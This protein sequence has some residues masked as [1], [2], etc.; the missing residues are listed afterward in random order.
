MNSV[1]SLQ[2]Y[3]VGAT[4]DKVR[5]NMGCSH[6]P[7]SGYLN[8]DWHFDDPR[9]LKTDPRRLDLPDNYA[10]EIMSYTLEH[11]PY[12]ETVSV[13]CEWLRV[14]KPGGL[15]D[16]SVPDLEWLFERWL[17]LPEEERWGSYLAAIFGLQRSKAD[18]HYVGFTHARMQ[19]LLEAAGYTEIVTEIGG[20]EYMRRI[21][22]KARKPLE[23]QP[24]VKPT[25]ESI[26]SALKP[27]EAFEEAARIFK[28]PL[29]DVDYTWLCQKLEYKT[30]YERANSNERVYWHYTKSIEGL[31]S[32]LAD[33]YKVVEQQALQI[34]Q[35]NDQIN[36]QSDLHRRLT[37]ASD[38]GASAAALAVRSEALR[39]E[40][41]SL[42]TELADSKMAL[43]STEREL[44]SARTTLQ[45][46]ESERNYFRTRWQKLLSLPGIAQL[47]RLRRSLR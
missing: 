25:E 21:L 37:G 7:R 20:E 19:E 40:L 33:S 16:V 35:L 39:V 44:S 14:L 26:A 12:T 9:I 34:E 18:F 31:Q 29:P 42:R 41:E 36:R 4:D 27:I 15:L 45:E 17:S 32:S 30:L 47:L 10:D 11:I 3:I 6:Y 38:A 8:V 43:A 23:P 22:V 28:N 46:V 5:I 13:L 1:A 2:A 24:G